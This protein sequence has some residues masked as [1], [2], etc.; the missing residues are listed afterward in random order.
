MRRRQTE[1]V[2]IQGAVKQSH[3]QWTREVK[4]GVG[5]DECQVWTDISKSEAPYLQD[6][7]ETC[8]GVRFGDSGTSKETGG[9]TGSG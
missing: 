6:G 4:H 7:S 1:K 2:N 9:L 5:G 3:K 8:A